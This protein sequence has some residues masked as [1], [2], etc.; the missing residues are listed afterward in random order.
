MSID[1]GLLFVVQYL[2]VA[3]P[4]P[5]DQSAG[6]GKLIPAERITVAWL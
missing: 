2:Y 1:C 6:S 4:D 5:E 3:F